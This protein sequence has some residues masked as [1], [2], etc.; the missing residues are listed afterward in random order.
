MTEHIIKSLFDWYYFLKKK[1]EI[2]E[3][4]EELTTINR[5]QAIVWHVSSQSQIKDEIDQSDC[6]IL[7]AYY[8]GEKVYYCNGAM[9]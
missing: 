6:L 3:E 5:F 1:E 2:V 8:F 7:T 9:L 4:T